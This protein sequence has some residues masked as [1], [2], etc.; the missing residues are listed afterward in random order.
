MKKSSWIYLKNYNYHLQCTKELYVFFGHGE[1]SGQISSLLP[2]ED[3]T[4][5]IDN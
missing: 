1:G 2:G 5:T 4:M 3:S